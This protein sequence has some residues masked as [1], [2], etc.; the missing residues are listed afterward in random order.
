MIYDY[1]DV[2]IN[3]IIIIIYYNYYYLLLLLLD[4]LIYDYTDVFRASQCCVLCVQRLFD[5]LSFWSRHQNRDVLHDGTLAF[6]AFLK[7]ACHMHRLLPD[8]ITYMHF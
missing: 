2:F 3:I 5:N 7:Q 6:D 4:Y 8:E 1:T